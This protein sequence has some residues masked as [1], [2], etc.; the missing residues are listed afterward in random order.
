MTLSAPP[1]TPFPDEY[2]DK[3]AAFHWAGDEISERRQRALLIGAWFADNWSAYQDRLVF[4][5]GPEGAAMTRQEQAIDVLRDWWGITDPDAL[6]DQVGAMHHDGHDTYY[7]IVGPLVEDAL[8]KPDPSGLD[9][10]QDEHRQFLRTLADYRGLVPDAYTRWYDT[11]LQARKLGIARSLPG[12]VP[13]DVR[14]WDLTRSVFLVRAGFTAGYLTDEDEC[15]G[16]L[17]EGLEI[18]LGLYSNWRQ[19]AAAY[20]WGY[21]F[22]RAKG[23]LSSVA[24]DTRSRWSSVQALMI[25][26]DAPWRRLPLRPRI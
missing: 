2:F 22:W 15:W 19:F 5:P 20:I 7:Q 21:A 23:D 17:E 9:R 14:A 8:V 13:P 25:R 1:L 11:W 10:I 4:E 12:A 24:K 6:R 3:V 18:A 26:A 16:R